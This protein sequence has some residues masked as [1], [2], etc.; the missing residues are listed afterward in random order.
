MTSPFPGDQ[1]N[2]PQQQVTPPQTDWSAMQSPPPLEPVKKPW[3]KR[4]WG[5]VL[6]GVMGLFSTLFVLFIL[7]VI[8]APA[9]QPLPNPAAEVP[10]QTQQEKAPTETKPQATSTPAAPENN[11]KQIKE[12]IWLAG[13]DFD[14]GTYTTATEVSGYCSWEINKGNNAEGLVHIDSATGGRPTVTIKE[15]LTF[16]SQGCGTWVPAK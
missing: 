16:N 11:R 3:Y 4:W 15:G 6:L 13:R 5:V 9:P 2:Y 8:F 1:F 12:G 10:L 14:P 7:I